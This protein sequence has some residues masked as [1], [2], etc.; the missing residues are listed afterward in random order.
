MTRRLSRRTFLAGAAAGGTL[1]RPRPSRATPRGTN[2]G[3][4]AILGGTPV[5]ERPFPSWPVADAAEERAVSD[6]I[7]SGQWFRGSG[8]YVDR[9]ETEYAKRTGSPHCLA[10]ANGTSALI[11]SLQ[12]LGVGAGDEV[13]VPPYTFVATVNAVLLLN[14]LPV[15]VDT[16]PATFQIDARKVEAAITEDTRA[17]VPVHLGGNAADLDTILEVANRRGIPVV[18]DAC[19]AHLSEW[20][21][22]KLGTYGKTGCFSFQAS[23]NLNAGEGGAILTADKALL[24][25]LYARHN[26]SRGRGQGGAD[27]S[28]RGAGV[29]LRMTEFQGAVLLA[30]MERLEEQARWRD[31]N[32][33]YL[34][35]QLQATSGLTPARMHPHCT[36]NAYHL[37]MTRYDSAQFAGLSRAAFLKALKA[38]GIP[39]MPGY[40]PLNRQPFL[41]NTLA[42]RG[43]QRV[44]S[45]ERLARWRERNH[46]PENDRLCEEGVWMTQTTLLGT[47]T[48]MD[49]IV[50]AVRK[51]KAAAPRIAAT[52]SD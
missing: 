20:K 2:G 42:T 26:N 23:K 28:Y 52:T 37:Y 21:G 44:F 33:A 22:R 25:A 48:D 7:R 16:D 45:N 13:I 34:T 4:A 39:M 5:R 9:F 50:E 38:E 46:C 51:V 36:R 29:N 49:H 41:E 35:Q 3:E 32:A 8:S 11:L 17:I 43:F 1:V 27:F 14:A 12:A 40:S 19:Q 47:T 18:E 6:V 24:D 31:Q 30:Q 10:T 15:F